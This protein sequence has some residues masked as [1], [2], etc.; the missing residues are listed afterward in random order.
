MTPGVVDISPGLFALVATYGS[1]QRVVGIAIHH[2]TPDQIA[3]EAHVILSE[4]HCHE[5]WASVIASESEEES[6]EGQSILMDIASRIRRAVYEGLREM[7][8]QTLV[9]VDVFID[10]L[11]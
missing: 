7:T 9:G 5:M 11:R 3:I 2:L 8:S 1:G 10:D 6:V 4:G